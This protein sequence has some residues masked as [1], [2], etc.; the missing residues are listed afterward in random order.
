MELE[1]KDTNGSDF[2][3]QYSGRQLIV[4]ILKRNRDAFKGTRFQFIRNHPVIRQELENK[5]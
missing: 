2:I 4:A 3:A 1:I 5:G